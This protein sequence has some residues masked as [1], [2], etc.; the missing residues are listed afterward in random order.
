MSTRKPLSVSA[1]EMPAH[2]IA[3]LPSVTLDEVNGAAS[4]QTRVDRKYILCQSEL[5]AVLAALVDRLSALEIEG[6]RS[7]G[8]ES[9]YF[10]TPN[11]E[12]FHAAAY[13][14]PKRCKIRT[15]S[16]VDSRKTMLEVK[17]KGTRAGTVKTRRPH[18][19][20]DRS[21]LDETAEQF[22]A[23]LLGH[24][25]FRERLQPVLK[26]RYDR[27]TL[28]D[29]GDASRLTIDSGLRCTAT[30]GASTGLDEVFI[31]ET[32]RAGS[33]CVADRQLWANGLR[34]IK[35]SKFGT[36]LAALDESLPSNKWHRTL[37]TYFSEVGK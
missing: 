26:T 7:F 23:V 11:L 33:P 10:D 1:A 31:V 14:R 21:V 34:P 17:T 6:Q 27:I 2:R 29:L 32:K 35:I 12:C 18:E 37:T 3:S 13:K 28:V 16:Y 8:Y 24:D 25:G 15:R 9:V 19:F 36:S 5:A 20:D 22:I 30:S 4:L